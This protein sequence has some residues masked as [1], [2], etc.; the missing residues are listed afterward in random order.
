VVHCHTLFCNNFCNNSFVTSFVTKFFFYTT[1]HMIPHITGGGVPA[2]SDI[3]QS[4]VFVPR[5]GT[6]LV[7]LRLATPQPRLLAV[8]RET[9]VRSFEFKSRPG[10]PT[11]RHGH[12]AAS[13]QRKPGKRPGTNKPSLECAKW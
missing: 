2:T 7:V 11:G 4:R 10:R 9:C 6:H 12:R 5:P 3:R 1:V 13:R 8:N